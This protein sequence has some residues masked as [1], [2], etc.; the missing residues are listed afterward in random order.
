MYLLTWNDFSKN[1]L[2]LILFLVAN[3]CL[4]PDRYHILL[5]K[6]DSKKREMVRTW[7]FRQCESMLGKDTGTQ[8]LNALLKLL[9]KLP[10]CALIDEAVYAVPGVE[11]VGDVS[12]NLRNVLASCDPPGVAVPKKEKRKK[13]RKAKRAASAIPPVPSTSGI[14]GSEVSDIGQ[15]FRPAGDQQLSSHI[16]FTTTEPM[17][18]KPVHV[19][20]PEDGAI[21]VLGREKS[22]PTVAQ[23][24]AQRQ[25]VMLV[26]ADKIR[27]IYLLSG[28]SKDA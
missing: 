7:L 25:L 12:D 5:G 28:V 24:A 17:A 8:L 20:M 23:T 13:Q 21:V 16:I 22:M 10:K 1:G 9:D 3:K 6:G 27:P 2:E 15:G 14:P 11:Y 4:L 18:R 19:R 26:E